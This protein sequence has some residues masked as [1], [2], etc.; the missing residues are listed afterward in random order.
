MRKFQKWF[1][2]ILGILLI[3]VVIV[4]AA[5][6]VKT[7][8]YG[9][10]IASA[11]GKILRLKDY[12]V[13]D[14]WIDSTPTNDHSCEGVRMLVEAGETLAAGNVVYVTSS[15]GVSAPVVYKADA[16][17]A[18]TM[19]ATA[20]LVMATTADG[21]TT[22]ALV[23]GTARDDTWNWTRGSAVY[24]STT[25]GG[26]TT[27]APSGSGDVERKVGIAIGA[28]QLLFQPE[29]YTTTN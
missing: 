17:A 26:L 1:L 12:V 22:Y 10:F 7:G 16:D 2:G 3:G 18:S 15:T 29:L 8:D 14:L 6:N 20:L 4:D 9:D 25:A 5:V 27:T 28:D 19:G 13:K 24:V 21:A 11:N 23:C